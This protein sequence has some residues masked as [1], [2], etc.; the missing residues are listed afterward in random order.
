MPQG[1]GYGAIE[2]IP[3]WKLRLRIAIDKNDIVIFQLATRL[4]EQGAVTWNNQKI[5]DAKAEL[6]LSQASSYILR[7]GKRHFVK[8]IVR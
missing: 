3:E 5:T 8:V 4:L 2:H 7:V 1:I 6:D